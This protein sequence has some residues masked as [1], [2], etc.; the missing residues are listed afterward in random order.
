MTWREMQLSLL[1]EAERSYGARKRK[2][3]YEAKAEEDAAA[4]RLKQA[5]GG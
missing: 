4:G 1:V 2:A 5:L 3:G